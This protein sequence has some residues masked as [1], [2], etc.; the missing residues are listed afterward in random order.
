MFCPECGS[1][2]AASTAK[3]C[4]ECGARFPLSNNDS[5]LAREP[6]PIQEVPPSSA[7]STEPDDPKALAE[8]SGRSPSRLGTV[9]F[10]ASMV[11]I[12]VVIALLIW[13]FGSGFV[14]GL[15]S[16]DDTSS[17]PTQVVATIASSERLAVRQEI[18]RAWRDTPED[19]RSRGCLAYRTTELVSDDG[20]GDAA[21]LGWAITEGSLAA[22]DKDIVEDEWRTLLEANCKD[23]EDASPNASPGEPETCEWRWVTDSLGFEGPPPY[24]CY[25]DASAKRYTIEMCLPPDYSVIDV[26]RG[27]SGLTVVSANPR[28]KPFDSDSL[29]ACSRVNSVTTR[30]WEFSVPLRTAKLGNIVVTSGGDTVIEL[31]PDVAP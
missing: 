1:R 15:M 12:A 21:G 9:I 30:I 6:A 5:A 24:N 17:A 8:E 22:F 26:E 14:S 29:S 20:Q 2:S 11:S 19:R 4:M 28:L 13:G 31:V 7:E 25:Y 23:L 18:S 16:D 27:D 3:F 10:Y